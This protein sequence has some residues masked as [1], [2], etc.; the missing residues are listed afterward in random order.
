L[1]LTFVMDLRFAL[2][3]DMEHEIILFAG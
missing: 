1:V 3:S 2:S